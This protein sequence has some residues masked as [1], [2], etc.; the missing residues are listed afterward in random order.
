MFGITEKLD[1]PQVTAFMTDFFAEMLGMNI[2]DGHEKFDWAHHLASQPGSG[3]NA[4]PRPMTMKVH[5]FRVKLHILQLAR[6]KGLLTYCGHLVHIYP[7]LTS[8][9]AKQRASY[10]NIK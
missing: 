8:E 2:P 7:D 3:T 6:E 4:I 10:N 5:H 1:G 9:I